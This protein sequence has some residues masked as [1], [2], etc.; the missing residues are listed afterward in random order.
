M[1]GI[2]A[3]HRKVAPAPPTESKYS[4]LSSED[5]N[6]YTFEEEEKS[7]KHASR[8][9][10]YSTFNA[11]DE[12]LYVL[13]SPNPDSLGLTTMNINKQENLMITRLSIESMA[14][15]NTELIQNGRFLF[16]LPDNTLC[17]RGHE[18]D[19]KTIQAGWT[20]GGSLR[21]VLRSDR[22]PEPPSSSNNDHSSDQRDGPSNE[23]EVASTPS[24]PPSIMARPLLTPSG[25]NT[26][27]LT[28]TSEVLAALR[29]EESLLRH[30]KIIKKLNDAERN[31]Q[32]ASKILND[33]NDG[34]QYHHDKEKLQY[35]ENI[36]FE[37]NCKL[38]PIDC[39]DEIEWRMTYFHGGTRQWYFDK[40]DRWVAS[41]EIVGNDGGSENNNIESNFNKATPIGIL[42]A[43]LGAGK[44]TLICKLKQLRPNEIIGIHLC[45]H[46]DVTRNDP[47]TILRSLAYQ[48]ATVSSS[49]WLLSSNT[50]GNNLRLSWPS[51]SNYLEALHR[52]LGSLR[53]HDLDSDSF[54]L[55]EIFQRLIVVPL[56]STAPP[57]D[58]RRRIL[59]IDGI[60]MCPEL[61]QCI[62]DCALL[63]PEWVGFFLTAR[64]GCNSATDKILT[65]MSLYL[66]EDEKNEEEQN[67]K[68]NNT[69][70][71]IE[72]SED[73]EKQ[74]E[75]E[76]QE[77][78]VSGYVRKTRTSKKRKIISCINLD[79][80]LN[81]MDV[82]VVLRS[83]LRNSSMYSRAGGES[84]AT[85]STVQTR[86]AEG[87]FAEQ[88]TRQSQPQCQQQRQQEE[89]HQ[90]QVGT[91]A[92]EEGDESFDGGGSSVVEAT[93]ALL[94]EAVAILWNK[95]NDSM[96]ISSFMLYKIRQVKNEPSKLEKNTVTNN[97][98]WQVDDDAT[99]NVSPGTAWLQDL[100]QYPSHLHE[101][102]KLILED[103][104]F[105]SGIE[106]IKER[107]ETDEEKQL[108]KAMK[109]AVATKNIPL[110]E[111]IK[112]AQ[113]EAEQKA[114]L[115]EAEKAKNFFFRH[116][117]RPEMRLFRIL[118]VTREPL[119]IQAVESM[120]GCTRSERRH[121]VAVLSN[122]FPIRNERMHAVHRGFLDW[123]TDPS[124]CPEEYCMEKESAKRDMTKLCESLLET[125]TTRSLIVMCTQYALE[126]IRR[127]KER[128]LKEQAREEA[129]EQRRLDKENG[130]ETHH[131]HQTAEVEEEE[132]EDDEEP[133]VWR[134]EAQ[135]YALR[136]IYPC[137]IRE[138]RV[139][140]ARSL[141]LTFEWILARAIEG[142][143][144]VVVSALEN[145]LT[146]ENVRSS[147]RSSLVSGKKTDDAVELIAGALRLSM[148][149]VY[150]DPWQLPSQLVGRLLSH[151][152]SS[153]E[154]ADLLNSA[155]KWCG[156]LPQS[157]CEHH[158][159][160]SESEPNKMTLVGEGLEGG[161]WCP[162]SATL[163]SPGG[164]LLCTLTGHEDGI[165]AI[166][167]SP[168]SNDHN[169]VCSAGRDQQIRL[170][171]LDSGPTSRL[172]ENGH[173]P[174]EGGFIHAVCFS[175]DGQ[176]IATVGD[177]KIV[178]IWS[179]SGG[180][181]V[182]R[183][184]GHSDSVVDVTWSADG[185][186]ICTGSSDWSVR[187]WWPVVEINE[188]TPQGN[189]Q[190]AS[191]KGDK[192]KSD[193]EREGGKELEEGVAEEQ[194]E[195]AWFEFEDEDEAREDL[196]FQID[197]AKQAYKMQVSLNSSPAIQK[198]YKASWIDLIQQERNL[199]QLFAQKKLE[200]ERLEKERMEKLEA[201]RL[202]KIE[203]TKD[204]ET[205]GK[206]PWGTCSEGE[207]N[208]AE[209]IRFQCVVLDGHEWRVTAVTMLSTDGSRVASSSDDESLRIYDV[210]L[211]ENKFEIKHVLWG[212]SGTVR[213]CAGAPD[214]SFLVSGGGDH[215][216]RV[217]DVESG[218]CTHV[219]DRHSGFLMTLE[220]SQDG[221]Q[222][223]S[224]AWDNLVC[225][226]NVSDWTI[227]ME[228]DSF[229]TAVL[230]IAWAPGAEP[231][232]LC[233]GGL[234]KKIQCWDLPIAHKE[235]NEKK[236][237]TVKSIEEKK[238]EE[239]KN[240]SPSKPSRVRSQKITSVSWSPDGSKICTTSSDW[241]VR[242]WSTANGRCLYRLIGHTGSTL[243]IGARDQNGTPLLSDVPDS[244]WVWNNETECFERDIE[245]HSGSVVSS[246]WSNDGKYIATGS[247]DNTVR[248]WDVGIGKC[249]N[250]LRGH[251]NWIGCVGFSP[252]GKGIASG[253]S[254]RTI[255]VYL[256]A[257]PI[258]I[259]EDT[260]NQDDS[261][262]C[263][264]GH[265][266][267]ITSV[268]W[269]PVGKARILSA[270][271][272]WSLRVWDLEQNT[273]THVLDE[274]QGTVTSAMW[275]FDGRRV[276]S[277]STD[278]TVRVWRIYNRTYRCKE[279]LEGHDCKVTSV[280]W[281]SDNTLILS[282]GL[283]EENGTNVII[284]KP[285][286]I[287]KLIPMKEGKE[288][289]EKEIEEENQDEVVLA[290][291]SMVPR[292]YRANFIHARNNTPTETISP[293]DATI[294]FS[295]HSDGGRTPMHVCST[296]PRRGYALSKDKKRIHILERVGGGGMC[297]DCEY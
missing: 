219:L 292:R 75:Q 218:E 135:F 61:F 112:E 196:L 123:L 159:E 201:E 286:S 72:K 217:W 255:R 277:G 161:W 143:P 278:G 181:C 33:E 257:T 100:N 108:R 66:D 164:P 20:Y 152:A 166:A 111:A 189:G 47:V 235:N 117:H 212:H 17:Q 193:E 106:K 94:D 125:A 237:L 110:Q 259:L 68:E 120:I 272:D 70:S 103:I 134:N 118:A 7:K 173:T 162:V 282:G 54:N 172:L 223:C 13:C 240:P 232:R 256:T 160:I 211:K 296:N 279:V 276:A 144:F 177:D 175:P 53:R 8:I 82:R 208:D 140:E 158:L 261:I 37:L 16:V 41:L 129:A 83:A 275:S 11:P 197:E 115:L 253:S 55:K 30:Q 252:D 192:I 287:K 154:I 280:A 14:K 95:S 170:W 4:F 132:E 12:Y 141:V 92:I 87:H 290:T 86:V 186:C 210:N 295:V 258:D 50:N 265:L 59:I 84:V 23:F 98:V 5:D 198:A 264:S 233:T 107:K 105:R 227:V 10:I 130:I 128:K 138:G 73:E 149:S 77:E 19:V 43:P 113:E 224:S 89:Q 251:K 102:Y 131:R 283:H 46:D 26:H 263:L 250:I 254:D 230:S 96:L 165:T 229:E 48:I 150:A 88:L 203:A 58:G 205:I 247:V 179:R 25:S 168:G 245:G 148:A 191:N 238:I 293:E 122:L 69:I 169:I 104:L 285:L 246:T 62:C 185:T 124:V 90:E 121:L 65:A 126:K 183:L 146:L 178:C 60:D 228:F 215:D 109:E 52:E 97:S 15:K 76:E 139:V 136:H 274:H 270:S 36:L 3:V 266:G 249:F 163:D 157:L 187:L 271:T 171:N 294:G 9:A 204:M 71:T 231:D 31:G 51:L 81:A 142:P 244:R 174:V 200:K 101:W 137:L 34:N 236:R 288:K 268:C 116:F 225:M 127:E 39:T 291:S 21:L 1:G 239:E 202:A 248:I 182:N 273:C 145:I 206:I 42:L 40:F 269:S 28:G 190:D 44:T 99:A 213:T 241:T 133:L 24:S 155:K 56:L 188:N 214:G 289:E 220:F 153:K 74:E 260:E 2:I 18:S 64:P 38:M 284:W 180:N 234:D 85:T 79:P 147:K 243:T 49:K 209:T 67:I 119:H 297:A 114:L 267:V 216:I 242:I 91:M 199:S 207:R 221:R 281:S 184:V 63:I 57:I 35:I 45:R 226:W 151:A 22:P 222:M 194:E 195:D 176:W 80:E 6:N 262:C 93:D 32:T 27:T 78:K 156:K 29:E 167:W